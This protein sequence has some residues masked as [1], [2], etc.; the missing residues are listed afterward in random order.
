MPVAGRGLSE[1]GMRERRNRRAGIDGHKRGG[2]R[3]RL[4]NCQPMHPQDDAEIKHLTVTF[5]KRYRTTRRLANKDRAITPAALKRN[6]QTAS[7]A[8]AIPSDLGRSSGN[9]EWQ[10]A[11]ARSPCDIAPSWQTAQSLTSD[12]SELCRSILGRQARALHLVPLKDR[13]SAF[14]HSLQ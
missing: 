8:S 4:M 11:Y 14:E 5:Q 1:F 12:K 7:S 3:F 2:D 10:R 9:P 13:Q 6:E